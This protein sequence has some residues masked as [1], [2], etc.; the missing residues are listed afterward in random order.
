MAWP[1]LISLLETPPTPAS[2]LSGAVVLLA[3]LVAITFALLAAGFLR[4]A[5]RAARGRARTRE[6]Q[7]T[8]LGPDPWFEA[9][10]RM[11]TPS[12]DSD[13]IARDRPGPGDDP[14]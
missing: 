13:E 1:A 14:R 11:E 5:K 9:G 10:R 12:P 3:V 2:R 8:N 4:A 6:N 7:Q